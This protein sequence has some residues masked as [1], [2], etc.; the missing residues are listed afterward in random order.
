MRNFVVRCAAV[1]SCLLFAAPAPG[2]AQQ[3]SPP[4]SSYGV[5]ATP[6][7]STRETR[8]NTPAPVLAM[9]GAAVGVV[10]MIAGA[11]TGAAIEAIGEC[12]EWCGFGGAILGGIVG[13]SIGV[14]LGVHL[15]NGARGKLV[16]SALASLA[17]STG[18]LLLFAV[19]GDTG[20]EPALL[21]SI[22]IAQIAT[23]IAIE[24]RT[25]QRPR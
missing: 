11:Y 2:H 22:P 13:E 24:R 25:A 4:L 23:S 10:G 8:P 19:L 12:S 17:I 21:W 18:G 20:A 14:P 7:D 9:G 15:L 16:P 3:A 5:P 1:L 6:V